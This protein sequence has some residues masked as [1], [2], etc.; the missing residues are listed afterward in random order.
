MINFR[1]GAVFGCRLLNCSSSEFRDFLFLETFVPEDAEDVED[2]TSLDSS[3]D[4]CLSLG[5]CLD[6]VDLI[7]PVF[8]LYLVSPVSPG[9]DCP[10]HPFCSPLDPKGDCL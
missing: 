1:C 6:I 7:S 2:D 3:L 4:T 9:M 8:P 5:S 10:C